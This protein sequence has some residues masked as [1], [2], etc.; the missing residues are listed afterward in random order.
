MLKPQQ[1]EISTAYAIKELVNLAWQMRERGKFWGQLYHYVNTSRPGHIYQPAV[2]S[3]KE[4]MI[5]TRE[6][7]MNRAFDLAFDAHQY[8]KIEGGQ[9][10]ADF[11]VTYHAI[12]HALLEV[13]GLSRPEGT[14]GKGQE[15]N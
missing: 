9:A 2:S 14:G 4:S 13:A 5:S 8:S 10:I 1:P 7:L 6:H 15:G 12:L 3:I 11:K